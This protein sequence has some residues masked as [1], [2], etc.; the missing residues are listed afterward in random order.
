MT[1]SR[2]QRQARILRVTRSIHR[3]LGISLFVFF[4]IVA[5]TGALL[6]WKK[7]VG[8]MQSRTAAGS[9]F[10][11]SEWKS[12]ASLTATAEDYMA[13]EHPELSAVID[14][15]D[16]RPSKGIVKI[17]FERHY[18]G[19]QL[20]GTTGNVLVD[21]YRR[22]DL[23]ENLHDGSFLDDKLGSGRLIKLFYTSI[24]SLAL[25]GF[26]LSGFWLWYGPKRMRR[27]R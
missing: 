6:G 1:Y 21:E 8:W 14:R 15:I 7:D 11:L 25:L 5:V 22:A 10:E 18:H 20:D 2:R 4:M 12:L 9:S 13:R 17:S 16:V 3:L 23:I 27:R 19:L 26:T 24:L